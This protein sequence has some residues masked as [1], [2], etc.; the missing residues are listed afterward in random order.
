M[1]LGAVQAHGAQLEQPHLAGHLQHLHKEPSEFIDEATTKSGQGVMVRV[2]TSGNVAK[3]H[4]VVSGHFQFA[5]G[6]DTGAVAVDKYGQQGG[7]VVCLGAATCVLAG[8]L[9]QV[10]DVNDFNDEARQVVLAESIIDRRGQQ[11][12]GFTVGE[13]EVRHAGIN[14]S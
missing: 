4:R 10:K 6:E 2:A 14:R 8:Q 3:G 1:N 5:A 13:D 11:V 12:V 7:G 9:R